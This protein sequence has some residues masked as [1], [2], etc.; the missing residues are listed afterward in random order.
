M[1]NCRWC[2]PDLEDV[3]SFHVPLSNIRKAQ[4]FASQLMHR[5]KLWLA[6]AV[7]DLV[8]IL[9]VAALGY[10]ARVAA[11][12]GQG[13]PSLRPLGRSFVLGLKVLAVMAA[14]GILTFL[15]AFFLSIGILSATSLGT[16]G[17]VAAYNPLIEL[18]AFLLAM[19]LAIAIL[20]ALGT[21]IALVLVA[22]H[23]V[24]AALN[25]A[26]SWRIIRRAG[27][28][29]YLA[30]VA[31]GLSIGLATLF[32]PAT[33]TSLFGVVGYLITLVLLILVEPIIGVF[34]WRWGGLIVEQS[35]LGI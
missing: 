25:P 6:L 21:P 7:L 22:K 4:S 28:G 14:Y 24:L 9:N 19:L 10:Y 16:Y 3:I 31:V 8:P 12:G 2:I 20:V 27:L 18:Y 33:A 29:E 15:V 23:G 34:L 17:H 35:E 13:L 5:P 11:E 30:Y 26:N 1:F 32:L